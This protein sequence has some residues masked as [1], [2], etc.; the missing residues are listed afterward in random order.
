VKVK[1]GCS[2]GVTLE[3]Y[4]SDNQCIHKNLVQFLDINELSDN[5]K[6][7]CYTHGDVRIDSAINIHNVDSNNVDSNLPSL[8]SVGA[9]YRDYLKTDEVGVVNQLYKYPTNINVIVTGGDLAVTPDEFV[10][11]VRR[12]YNYMTQNNVA[13][14]SLMCGETAY[15]GPNEFYESHRKSK[16]KCYI[17]N[18]KCLELFKTIES[19]DQLTSYIKIFSKQ[20]VIK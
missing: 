12:A 3:E 5:G 8:T 1:P 16:I 7:T 10:Q 14:M 11:K 20:S 17:V 4:N 6:F 13:V 15:F 18:N 19:Y 9:I 2:Y